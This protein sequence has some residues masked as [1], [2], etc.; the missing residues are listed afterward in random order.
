MLPQKKIQLVCF[1]PFFMFLTK[2]EKKTCQILLSKNPKKSGIFLVYRKNGEKYHG[3][4][5]TTY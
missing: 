1:N 3:Q 5:S 4:P 2:F